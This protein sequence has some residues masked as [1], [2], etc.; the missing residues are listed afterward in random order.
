MKKISPETRII[1]PTSKR[2]PCNL[3]PSNHSEGWLIELAIAK[4]ATHN[5][6][7]NPHT[8]PNN[9]H[10]I[11]E[12]HTHLS[13][14]LHLCRHTPFSSRTSRRHDIEPNHSDC[15]C[16]RTT[17]TNARYTT[18]TSETT[19][20]APLAALL[21]SRTAP[22]SRSRSTSALKP[23]CRPT[24]TSSMLGDVSPTCQRFYVIFPLSIGATTR[25]ALP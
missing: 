17:H 2:S 11:R 22:L 8:Q 16:A 24:A 4:R 12:H 25:V 18:R 19:T 13:P 21:L 7:D 14:S 23:R 5:P 20:H 6:N 3:K 10:H 9:Q 1:R 15:T